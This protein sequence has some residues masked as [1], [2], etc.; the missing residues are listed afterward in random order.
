MP[1]PL[2]GV[3]Q[4]PAALQRSRIGPDPTPTVAIERVDEE[5]DWIIQLEATAR[6]SVNI[7]YLALGGPTRRTSGEA[8]RPQPP[9]AEAG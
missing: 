5:K 8:L 4:A 1:H 6:A 7:P 3:D 9:A 2:L